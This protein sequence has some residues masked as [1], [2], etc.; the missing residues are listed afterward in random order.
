[1][2]KG[3]NTKNPYDEEEPVCSRTS[4]IPEEHINKVRFDIHIT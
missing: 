2:E 4:N 1:M 3:G